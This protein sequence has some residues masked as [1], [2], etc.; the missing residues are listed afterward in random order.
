[1]DDKQIELIQDDDPYTKVYNA[2]ILDDR[3]RL[4]TRMVLIMMTSVPPDWDFSIRGMAKIAHVTKDTMSKMLAEL[5]EAGYVKRKAQTRGSAGQFAKAGYLVSRKPIFGGASDTV[6][7]NQDTVDPCPNSSYTKEPYTKNSPQLNNKQLTTKQSSSPYSPPS[8]PE[9]DGAV[10]GQSP[11]TSPDSP[12]DFPG[13]GA[14][15][16]PGLAGQPV[17]NPRRTRQK[18]SI[19]THAPER[20]EQFWSYYP[21]PSGSRLKAVAEWD[22]LAPSEALIDEM[23]RALRRQKASR[24]W[25]EGIG[26]PHAFRWI[27]DRRW[28][29]KLSEAPQPQSTGGWAPDP[30]VTL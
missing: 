9:A 2:L 17:P 25:Q 30:E 11:M 4:Q 18:K 8:Q 3:L 29:D 13:D 28:T 19:P 5:E 7:K 26:I 1:M 15:P 10:V 6:P 27:R 23:A 24:Q 22:A 16:E 21:E 14:V 12:A 20:F